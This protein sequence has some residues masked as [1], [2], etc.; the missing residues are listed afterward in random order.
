MIGYETEEQQVQ[1]IKQFW[2][3]NGMAIIAGAVIG[4]GLLWGWRFYN[5]SQVTAKEQSSAA[6]TAGLQS[7][8]DDG[9]KEQ[10]AAF[11]VEQKDT[12]YAPLAAMILAQKAVEEEDYASA[13]TNL[14]VAI[15]GDPAIADIAR[16]RL[17]SVHLQLN[18]NDEALAVLDALE[19]SSF[20]NQV[21]ELRGDALLAKGDFDGAQNAYTIAMA[22]TPN[23]PTLKMKRDN[24]AFAKTQEVDSNVE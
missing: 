18:E 9:E 20:E 5:D 23:S 2:K 22:Q 19:S 12:A 11:I 16:L 10:L 7:F 1:A 15:S 13:K 8:V 24:I 4:L 3:D 21:E 17:A 6:Y 14:L